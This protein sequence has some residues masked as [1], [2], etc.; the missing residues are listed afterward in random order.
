MLE[1]P[2]PEHKWLHQLVGNWVSESEC[3]KAPEE[4]PEKSSGRFVCCS[5][6]ELWVILEGEGAAPDG[7]NW[8]CVITL[9]YD[10]NQKKY[11]GN[12]IV[13]MMSH[14]WPYQGA[15]DQSGKKLAL[16][17]EGPRCDGKEGTAQYRDTIEIVDKDHWI[18][19]G[20]VQGDDGSWT[21]IMTSHNYRAG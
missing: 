3:R 6:G 17:S 12:S 13:S 5:L 9:G 16:D 7:S 19:T 2:Q 1:N 18:F 11:V 8:K 14:L 21:Q 4:K 10:P 15:L 20:E